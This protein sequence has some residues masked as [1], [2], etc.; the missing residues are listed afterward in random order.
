[1]EEGRNGGDS[2]NNFR[3][4]RIILFISF[5]IFGIEIVGGILSHSL[6]LFSDAWHVFCDKIAIV[7]TIIAE[8]L[9]EKYKKFEE[10]IQQTVF[11]ANS[12]LLFFVAFGIFKESL[13]R[14]YYPRKITTSIFIT[15]AVVGALGNFIQRLFLQKM[16]GGLK[17]AQIILNLHILSDLWQ[18]LA[19]ILGGVIIILTGL[20]IVDPI[21]SLIIAF[22]MFVRVIKLINKFN[23]L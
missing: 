7:F 22:L 11:I 2:R 5:I 9:A 19:I 1:M 3:R 12:I 16:S 4:Y 17:K 14:I 13:L 8:Y 10:K 6:A 18:S 21:L 20:V 23:R 15:I